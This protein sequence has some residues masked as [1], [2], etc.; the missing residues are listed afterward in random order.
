M[1]LVKTILKNTEIGQSLAL[2]KLRAGT[3]RN[4]DEKG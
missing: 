2:I 4:D 3:R 1:N